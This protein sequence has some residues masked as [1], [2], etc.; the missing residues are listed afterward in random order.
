MNTKN[1]GSLYW[2]IDTPTAHIYAYADLVKITE[3][4]DLLLKRKE[5]TGAIIMTAFAA[6]EWKMIHA[7]SCING[8]SMPMCIE[9]WDPI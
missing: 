4:G 7:T 8:T 6:K 2:R 9:H 5:K 1:K 3:N